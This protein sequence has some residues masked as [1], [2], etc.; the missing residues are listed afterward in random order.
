MQNAQPK[1]VLQTALLQLQ[2]SVDLVSGL[3]FWTLGYKSPTKWDYP[4]HNSTC[5]SVTKFREP[6]TYTKTT[7]ASK[8]S[9]LQQGRSHL[10][11][12]V[13]ATAAGYLSLHS[14]GYESRT[15]RATTLNPNYAML[16]YNPGCLNFAK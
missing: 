6:F 12:H 10:Q 13:A 4:I 15:D 9:A 16:T 1:T 11:S 7:R 2:G 5:K 8:P 14:A 3:S